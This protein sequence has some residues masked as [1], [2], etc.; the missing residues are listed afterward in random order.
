MKRGA[1]SSNRPVRLVHVYS[2]DIAIAGAM[3]Y[4]RGALA[5]GWD[6]TLICPGGPNSEQ[7]AREGV[8]W[9]PLGLTRTLDFVGDVTGS[10]QLLRDL[11]RGRFDVVHTHNAKVG[12][13]GR[14]LAAVAR[15]PVIVHTVHGMTWSLTTP[16]PKQ[17]A[18]AVAERFSS[19]R[20]DAILTQSEED[21]RTL[22]GRRVV[23]PERVTLIGNGVNL[24]RFNLDVIPETDR[25]AVRAE[26]GAAEGDV[27]FV[28]AG[29]LVREKGF[30]ELFEAFEQAHAEE[31]R[32]RLAVAGPRDREKADAI[33]DAV[34][35]RALRAG[36]TFL[37][38]RTDMPAIFAAC[39]V[40]V[41]VSWREGI[42]RVL[43]EASSLA[44]PLLVSDIRGCKEIVTGPERGLRVAVKDAGAIAKAMVE[45]A[46]D[47]AARA[48]MGANNSAVAR[49]RHDIDRVVARVMAVYDEALRARGYS[50]E[51]LHPRIYQE[52][53][54]FQTPLS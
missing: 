48:R 6:V 14:V 15:A 29:R 16:E 21:T 39:D 52:S 31:P 26:A 53:G 51:A 37:G 18:Y 54:V 20:T 25:L 30:V 38:D 2:S 23:P 8:R 22:V 36:V 50:N 44:K 40:G 19:L 28:Q 4:L 3:P 11:V 13:V 42:P 46:R 34:V 45:L 35:E 32:V 9:M 33:S 1:P 5:R 17:T 41:L 24:S 43:M 12:L 10:A 27:L 49:E 47:P 7:A